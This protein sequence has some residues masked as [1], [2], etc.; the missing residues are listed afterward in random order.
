MI[1]PLLF[2][3]LQG[4]LLSSCGN[5]QPPPETAP[6][7]K[8]IT[9]VVTTSSA[10]AEAETDTTED[11]VLPPAAPP[12]P[13]PAPVERLPLTTW[14]SWAPLCKGYPSKQNCDDGDAT[15]FSGLLCLAG[16][17]L[18]CDA[19]K[20]AQDNTGKF[21]RSPRRV[22]LDTSNSFSRDMALGVLAYL[23]ATKDKAGAQSWLKWIDQNSVCQVNVGGSCQ[24]RT[25][26]FCRDDSDGRCFVTPGMW[27]MMRRVWEHLGLPLH[28]EMRTL[29]ENTLVAETEQAAV[30][31]QLHL[32]SV[33]AL[34]YQKI[35]RGYPFEWDL[36]NIISERQP[37]N[38]FFRYLQEGASDSLI[39][40]LQSICPLEAPA[41]TRQWTWERVTSEKAQLQSMGWDCIFL[42][43]LLLH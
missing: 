23:V 26:R 19:V 10:D 8:A 11:L 42:A 41:E 43:R 28:G 35:G 7:V 15:L 32:K 27:S 12:S 3:L 13:E 30:G 17:N 20:A 16:E 36:V 18:G 9:P 21:W 24:L 4:L 29:G 34:I 40:S 31:Y 37:D 22:G 2:A 33:M 1:R 25:F 38:L 39:Q 6:A 5:S 14:K